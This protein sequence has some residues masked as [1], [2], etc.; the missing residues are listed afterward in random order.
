M[1]A[2]AHSVGVKLDIEAWLNKASI[3]ALSIEDHKKLEKLVH[4]LADLDLDGINDEVDMDNLQALVAQSVRRKLSK[5]DRAD[6]R[7]GAAAP[8]LEAASDLL[9]FSIS[10]A[11]PVAHISHLLHEIPK[12]AGK[13]SKTVL[14][15]KMLHA[16]AAPPDNKITVFPTPI[17]IDKKMKGLPFKS[18]STV[19]QFTRHP[20]GDA[21]IALG[22]AIV[23]IEKPVGV[24]VKAWAVR[25][26]H[27][28][29]LFFVHHPD[30]DG[31]GKAIVV[32]EPNVARNKDRT[33]KAILEG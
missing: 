25:D 19:S 2:S 20:R 31:P 13:G 32:G 1:L 11:L 14:F 29:L 5:A 3:K 27:A 8:D 24:T 21:L 23:W 28:N 16:Y 15:L 30:R 10:A 7:I 26:H 6:I 12:T 18:F 33:Q 17:F 22:L 4:K 9:D